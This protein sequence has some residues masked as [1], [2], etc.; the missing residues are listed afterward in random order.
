LFNTVYSQ[1]VYLFRQR[2]SIYGTIN[3]S[4]IYLDQATLP[5]T[6]NTYTVTHTKYIRCTVLQK[7]RIIRKKVN[8][9]E[10]FENNFTAE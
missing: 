8:I 2:L 1:L 7:Y 10:H 3:Q 9:L 4:I 5:V 6:H